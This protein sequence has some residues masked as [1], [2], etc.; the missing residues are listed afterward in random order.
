M[1]S[2]S[3]I[4][5][6]EPGVGKTTLGAT[7]PA[8]RL[9]LDIEG[10]SRFLRH[11]KVV[12][13]PMIDAPPA[14]DGTWESCIVFVRDY[15]EVQQVYQW[16]ASGQHPFR[17]LIIDS[18]TEAQKRLIDQVAGVQQPTQQD[19]G[20]ILRALE[21]FV[22]KVRDLTFHADKVLEVVLI[23]CLSHMRDGK[24]RPWVKGQLE[25]SLPG[26]VDVQGYLYVE[27][28]PEGVLE[29]KLLIAPVGTFDAKDRTG[30]LTETYGPVI[31]NP[32]LQQMLEVIFPEETSK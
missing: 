28:S 8:P 20:A 10:G 13:N 30:I 29:R 3:L 9:I 4:V 1:K 23:I 2:L 19:W 7:A 25:L 14:Y 31:V 6:G 16:L 11:A 26:F 15:K 27:T 24:F 5:H 22:R 17:S 21:D 18:L 32:N 12:W